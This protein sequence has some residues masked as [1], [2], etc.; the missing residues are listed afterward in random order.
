MAGGETLWEL[1]ASLLSAEVEICGG[2]SPRV[3]PA[4]GVADLGGLLQRAGFA[5]P[6]VDMDT[7]TVS[8]ADPL[9][10]PRDLRAMGEANAVHARRRTLTP[11]AVLFRAA[12]IYRARHGDGAGRVPAT[13][14]ILFL[15]GWA[16]HESQPRA[17]RPG[18]AAAR[19]AEALDVPETATGVKARPASPKTD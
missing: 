14:Q 12:E 2:A 5:L 9:G 11:R 1:R 18:S 13:F 4:A 8:Y 16:P 19:L 17:L 7:I 10:L 15:T 6:M 3:S